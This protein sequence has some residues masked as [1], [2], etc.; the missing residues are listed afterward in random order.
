MENRELKNIP[1]HLTRLVD[2]LW[3]KI[4]VKFYSPMNTY[5]FHKVNIGLQ[6]LNN[7]IIEQVKPTLTIDVADVKKL[8]EQIM[9][10]VYPLIDERIHPMNPLDEKI[11][12]IIRQ[13]LTIK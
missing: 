5:D 11:Q 13:F 8:T 7:F 4:T 1:E 3:D 10:E 6:E 9:G 2:A 12:S